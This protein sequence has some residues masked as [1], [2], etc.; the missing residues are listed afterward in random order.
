MP[1]SAITIFALSVGLMA[2]AHGGGNLIHVSTAVKSSS[3]LGW[4]FVRAICTIVGT[5]ITGMASQ[6][7]FSRFATKPGDQ[8]LGQTFAVMFFG[9]VVPVFGV[10]GTSAASKLY[11]DVTDLGLWNPASIVEVWLERSYDDPKMRAA[12][13]FVSLGFL[14]AVVTMNTVENGI[15]GGMDIAGLWPQYINI[16]RGSYIL[17]VVSILIQPWQIIGKAAT[18]VSV[19]SSFGGTLL[20][21]RMTSLN[22]N[23]M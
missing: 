19:L 21:G 6:S 7:D 17:A 23:N 1:I 2:A 8:V 12:S 10:L 4:T 13:F 14:C 11:G 5:N 15:S 16:R 18:F 9:N 3:E 20:N 22:A